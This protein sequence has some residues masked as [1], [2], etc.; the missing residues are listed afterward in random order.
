MKNRSL[1]IFI[2]LFSVV[3]LM[4]GC[5]KEQKD[6]RNSYIGNWDFTVE[7]TE[8]NIDSI[9]YY[10]QDS[11]LYSGKIRIGSIENEINIQY[12]ESDSITLIINKSGKISG[13]PTQYCSGEF[14]GKL[15][16]HLYLRWGG[17]G[18]GIIHTIDGVKK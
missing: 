13:F 1:S 3:M 12:A 10:S 5:G 14:E 7:L 2:I 4:L 9:G 8:F 15:K 6:Y 17:I 18:G 11:V 16:L